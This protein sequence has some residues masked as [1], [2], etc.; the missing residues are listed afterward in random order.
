M[1]YIGTP[2]SNAFTSLL[3]QDFSTSATTGYTLDHAVNNANDI[4]LFINFVRQEP[5][6]GY[7][8]SGTTLTLTSATA[9]SDDMYCVYLG[10]ALQTVNPANASVG[11]TQLSPTAITG[12]TALTSVASDD[13]VLISDTSASGA[14]KKMTRANFVSG[15]GGD[16]TP[17]F[18]AYSDHLNVSDNTFTKVPFA[19][20]VFDTN[21]NFASNRFTPTVAG[22]YA[23]H[24]TVRAAVTSSTAGRLD[25]LTVAFYKNGS[26]YISEYAIDYRSNPGAL[27]TVTLEM[28]IDFN[29]SGDY[30]EVYGR[31]DV[32]S[33]T[34]AFYS[35]AIFGAYK[36][37]I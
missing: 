9:S 6:A 10:Q 37:I 33:N 7:A 18:E 5:T 21:N 15:I 36:I 24:T 12:Q 35:G 4:A 22:K 2:P 1:S 29:G 23:C 19:N 32:N 34:P 31:V 16:N 25:E 30:L 13:T 28:T 26:A 20:E 3:K 8:A 27:A 17:A 14:L 11:S